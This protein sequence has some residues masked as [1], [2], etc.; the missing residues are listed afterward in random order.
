MKDVRKREQEIIDNNIVIKE[1][2]VEI[3][4]NISQLKSRDFSST[5]PSTQVED[6]AEED[7]PFSLSPLYRPLHSG[8]AIDGRKDSN[9][10]P[11]KARENRSD[12]ASNLNNRNNFPYNQHH[13]S[14]KRNHHNPSENQFSSSRSNFQRYS[15]S[16]TLKSSPPKYAPRY[17]NS[18]RTYRNYGYINRNTSDYSYQRSKQH[19][20]RYNTREYN[21]AFQDRRNTN[22]RG[23]QKEGIT[24][25][26]GI[27]KTLDLYLGRVEMDVSLSSVKKYIKENLEFE[28]I[29][30][31]ELNA[32]DENR[33]SK[34]FK[35]T[36]DAELR[37]KLL[38]PELWPNGVIIRKFTTQKRYY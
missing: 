5:P 33:E 11:P 9:P 7:P 4:A 13:N 14:N 23:S 34:S 32:E 38:V 31:I 22:I 27:R 26:K 2:I 15:Y 8:T 18:Y 1:E 28:I 25:F 10:P 20:D 17:D 12:K 37:D 29:N 21:S 19:R 30:C 36:V 24:D 16:D 6:K 3:K 35:I